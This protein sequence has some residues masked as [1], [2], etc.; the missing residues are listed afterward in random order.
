M[1]S[2]R[3]FYILTE[4]V[5]WRQALFSRLSM[6]ENNHACRGRRWCRNFSDTGTGRRS[7]RNHFSI[8]RRDDGV[9]CDDPLHAF[10]KFHTREHDLMSAAFALHADI[11]TGPEH[12]PDAGAAWMFLLHLHPVPHLKWL[13][14]RRHASSLLF[15]PAKRQGA[16]RHPCSVE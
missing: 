3:R 10:F 14:G 8:C 7:V 16:E 6:P 11:R 12:F 9:R 15:P 5:P 2:A 4:G 13:D 1:L